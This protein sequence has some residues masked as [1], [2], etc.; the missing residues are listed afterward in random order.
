MGQDVDYNAPGEELTTK[1]LGH[2]S[3]TAE[4]THRSVGTLEAPGISAQDLENAIRN[5]ALDGLLEYSEGDIV[6]GECPTTAAILAADAPE[7]QI[8]AALEGN[9]SDNAAKLT[10]Q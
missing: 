6:P 7:G 5:D 1:Q 4:F 10:A 3:C 8:R 2:A 9:L